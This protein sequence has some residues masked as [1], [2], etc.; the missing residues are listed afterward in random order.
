MNSLKMSNIFF[1]LMLAFFRDFSG[2][3]RPCEALSQVKKQQ[4]KVKF[5]IWGSITVYYNVTYAQIFF[6][7]PLHPI[8]NI[9]IKTV[10]PRTGYLRSSSWTLVWCLYEA[11][12]PEITSLS[13]SQRTQPGLITSWGSGG[14]ASKAPAIIT[15]QNKLKGSVSRDFRPPVFFMIRTHLGP[16]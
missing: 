9:Y 16:W 13:L 12:P 5:W 14:R 8:L 3:L 15:K 10:V 4:I 1:L 2:F 6:Q 7:K 11:K